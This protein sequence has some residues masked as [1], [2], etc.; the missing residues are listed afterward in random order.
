MAILSDFINKKAIKLV[1]IDSV[2]VGATDGE[3]TV[4]IEITRSP[5]FVQQ[6]TAAVRN[7]KISSGARTNLRHVQMEIVRILPIILGEPATSV[8]SP[9]VSVDSADRGEMNFYLTVDD[10]SAGTGKEI[11]WIAPKTVPE[12]TITLAFERETTMAMPTVWEHLA[13]NNGF[14]GKFGE[15]ANT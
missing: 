8:A 4:E 10:D 1:E 13:D 14:I 3:G 11:Q 7:P 9:Y 12:G 5:V 6:Q 15:I 2:D